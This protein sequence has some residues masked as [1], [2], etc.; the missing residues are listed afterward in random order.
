MKE[1][2][3]KLGNIIKYPMIVLMVAIPVFRTELAKLNLL[4]YA[5]YLL[6]VFCV[7]MGF[8]VVLEYLKKK[9]NGN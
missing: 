3:I 7:L 4:I 8:S 1:I 6:L 5:G 9:K 2:I